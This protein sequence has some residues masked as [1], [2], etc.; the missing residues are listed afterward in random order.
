MEKYFKYGQ[1]YPEKIAF[2]PLP[3]GHYWS[4]VS[5][6]FLN[7]FINY[8]D[9]KA[10]YVLNRYHK[11]E[12]TDDPHWDKTIRIM[13]PPGSFNWTDFKGTKQEIYEKLCEP[14]PREVIYAIR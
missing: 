14:A 13:E 8:V 9:I 7:G 4:Y 5:T 12:D 11:W 2:D 6:T 10:A 1:E 3:W